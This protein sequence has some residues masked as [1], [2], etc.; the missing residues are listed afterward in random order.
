MDDLIRCTLT[1]AYIPIK[2]DAGNYSEHLI[3]LF[4]LMTMVDTN[5]RATINDIISNPLIVNPF[6]ASYFNY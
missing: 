1:K 3:T 6:Y 5:K 4:E 2:N